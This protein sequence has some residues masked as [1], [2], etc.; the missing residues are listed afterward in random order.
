MLPP[1][2]CFVYMKKTTLENCLLFFSFLFLD[3]F[4]LRFSFFSAFSVRQTC[5]EMT[6]TLLT[7][8]DRLLKKLDEEM[9]T[10]IQHFHEQMRQLTSLQVILGL[11]LSVVRS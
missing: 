4:L 2:F 9:A 3:L 1:S 8:R 7:V 5:Q 11:V 6:D 10:R